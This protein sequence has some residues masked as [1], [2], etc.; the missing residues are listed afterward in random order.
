MNIIRTT[1][2]GLTSLG[3]FGVA[4]DKFAIISELWEQKAVDAIEK[5]LEVPVFQ[6]NVGDTNLIG[7]LAIANSNGILVPHIVSERDLKRL[8]EVLTDDIK[9][10]VVPSKLT[11]LANCILANDNGAIIHEKFEPEA[12]SIIKEVFDVDVEK[13]NIINSPLV[14]S[15]AIATNRGV[16][17][18][19]LTTE[20]EMTWLSE[21][22]GVPVNVGTMNRGTPYVSIGVFANS[23]GAVTGKDTTG[24]ELQRLYQTLKGS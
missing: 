21:K 11:C 1:V 15:H 9:I 2:E 22:L 5:A 4:T 16:L 19:P 23:R 8:Q 24:P 17:T 18:H 14:G 12:V 13:G 20:M 3:A 7:I 6:V 10:G